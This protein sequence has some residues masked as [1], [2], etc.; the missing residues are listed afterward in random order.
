MCGPDTMQPLILNGCRSV[1]NNACD[2]RQYVGW[3]L[4]ASHMWHT[5]DILEVD[6][7]LALDFRHELYN[8]FTN[9]TIIP[10]SAVSTL[11][12]SQI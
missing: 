1:Y 9:L 12:S 3:S 11:A 4:L 7:T 5:L 2:R 10:D 6:H 8:F